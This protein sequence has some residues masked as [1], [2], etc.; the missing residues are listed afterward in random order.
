VGIGN[1]HPLARE[2]IA[3]GLALG[4]LLAIVER[5]APKARAWLPSATG[6]GLGLILPFATALSFALGAVLAWI[7][8]RLDPRQAERFVIPISS[9]LIAGESIVGVLVAALNNFVLK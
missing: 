7:Y 9:G 1:L 8:Q 6:L 2:G 4:A 3:I 5:V